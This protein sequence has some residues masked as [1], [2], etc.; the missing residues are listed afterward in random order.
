MQIH[1]EYLPDTADPPAAAIAKQRQWVGDVREEPLSAPPHT[2][3]AV[4]VHLGTARAIAVAALVTFPDL[5][6]RALVS[7]DAPLAYPYV[8][9]HPRRF[10]LACH[11][12]LITG[13]P[14]VGC[15]KSVLV[16]RYE[17]LAEAAGSA[18]P[19]VDRGEVVGMALRTRAGVAPVFVSVGHRITLE[20]AVAI[21]RQ[22][23]TRTKLPE[24]S[25]LAHRE[26]QRL[27]RLDRA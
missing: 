22:A 8:P 21:V 5:A 26:A 12:G 16:G 9:A 3:A 19:L 15:A 27:A 20:A 14:T 17:A 24:P 25:R 11:L 18:A 2:L 4:D 13:L 6:S 10:G 1:A 7:A 23:A